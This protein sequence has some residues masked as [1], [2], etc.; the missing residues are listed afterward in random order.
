ML[1]NLGR[2]YSSQ[3]EELLLKVVEKIGGPGKELS[4][5]MCSVWYTRFQVDHLLCITV[6]RRDEQ[7]V[8]CLLACIVYGPDRSVRLRDGLYS[9]VVH[10]PRVLPTKLCR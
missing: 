4:S 5:G 10:A 1:N 8:P 2:V 7:D 3:C 9:C 6:V